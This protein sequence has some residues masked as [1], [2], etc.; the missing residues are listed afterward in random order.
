MS[1]GGEHGHEM[2]HLFPRPKQLEADPE[3]SAEQVG[4]KSDH[5]LGSETFRDDA[6]EEED[7]PPVRGDSVGGNGHT[8][9]IQTSVEYMV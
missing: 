9:Q 3:E 1:G 2:Q 6:R 5:K 7:A 8:E 4:K